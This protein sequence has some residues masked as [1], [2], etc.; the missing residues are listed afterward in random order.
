MTISSPGI[1]SNLDV[2]GI[3]TK[4]MSVERVPLD[5]LVAQETKQRSRL[6]AYGSLKSYVAALQTVSQGLASGTSLKIQ[7][8]TVSDPT[9]LAATAG[10][11][12]IPGD[13]AIEVNALARAAKLA[14][15]GFDSSSAI[16]GS[17]S[18]TVTLGTYDSGGNTFTA[19]AGTPVTIAIPPTAD[20][21]TGVRDAINA[22][23][24]GVTAAIINDGSAS[25]NRLVITANNSGAA[26]SMRIA[27][28]DDDGNATDASGLSRFAFDPTATVGGGRNLTEVQ[29][30]RN[31]SLTIDGLTITK[32]SN[33][34]TDAIEGVTLNLTK[35]NTGTPATVTVARDS[36]KIQAS[37]E[38][39]VKAYNDASKA[40]RGFTGYDATTRTAGIL[41]GDSAP[42]SILSQM[43]NTI[44]ATAAGGGAYSTLADIGISFQGDGSIKL[45]ASKVQAAI[46]SN[47]GDLIKLFEASATASDAQVAYVGAGVDTKAGTYAVSVSRLG[48]AGTLTGSVSAGLTITAG[49]N[50][51]IDLSI[52]GAVQGA[53]LTPGVYASAAA[54]ATEIQ[55]RFGSG[56]AVSASGGVLSVAS[57]VIGPASTVTNASGNGAVGLFG[58]TPAST[59]GVD[60]A[61]SINGVA[62]TGV[63]RSLTGATG[64]ASAGL[65]I[66]IAGGGTG[67]RGSVTY[68]TGYGQNMYQITSNILAADG[69]MTARSDGINSTIK[70]LTNREEAMQRRLDAIE[71]R[72]RAQFTALDVTVSS[73]QATSSY[74]TQQ[75]TA[76]T[77]STK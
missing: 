17:G 36:A 40:I 18:L 73:L 37:L 55:T 67:A 29:A 30:A 57:A 54:L 64:D 12:A 5:N 68:A 70:Q 41:S 3:V 33:V 6:S 26:N 47:F 4:L 52:N 13:Y 65:L 22:A 61:G 28:T 46:G 63:G 19:N 72:Y 38:A 10:T 42:R 1:G 27:V 74:L 44:T 76:L 56:I 35:I 20:T 32:A 24:A 50:D 66:R 53:T 31:A 8:T 16:V 77:K 75:L 7:T 25:G 9:V 60:V 34:I 62:A 71:M 48:A 39:F 51:R 58:A 45:D 11:K 59:T 49:V 43:R 23:G 14:S 15:T 69:L 2:N 21:L